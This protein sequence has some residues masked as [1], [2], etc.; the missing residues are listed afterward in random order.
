[1]NTFYVVPELRELAVEADKRG[2]AILPE[3]GLDPG[4]DLVLL[5]EAVRALDEVEDISTYGA[6][7]PEREAADNPLKYKVSW[8]FDGV[9]KAYRRA[10][11]VV[12]DGK[13]VTIGETEMFAPENVHEV[14]IEGLG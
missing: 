5:A 6:G 2:V 7:I 4:I 8:T 1:M 11:R 9:L 14:E 3:F 12:R 10:G 13:V